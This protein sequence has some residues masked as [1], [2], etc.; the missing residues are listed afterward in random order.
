M[1]SPC[2]LYVCVPQRLKAGIVEH[3]A[4]ARQWLS[5][6]IPMA[7]DTHATTEE[8]LGVV[9]STQCAWYQIFNM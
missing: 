6:H 9:F 8:L 3:M 4:V 2:Y 1:I 7:T 5:K